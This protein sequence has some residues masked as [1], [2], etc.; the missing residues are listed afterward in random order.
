MFIARRWW[1]RKGLPIIVTGLALGTALVLR[2]TDG[3]VISELYYQVVRPF[4][5]NPQVEDI[6]RNSRI[7]E[8]EIRVTEL[9]QQNQQLKALVGYFEKQHGDVITAPIVGRSADYW[10]QQVTIG[11]G[12]ADGIKEGYAVTGVGGLIGRVTEVTPNTSR[13]LLVSDPNSRV[14]AMVVRSRYMG[15]LQGQGSQT[16]IMRFFDKVPDVKPGDTIATSSVSRLFPGGLPIGK[17]KSVNVTN[18]PAPEAVIEL[19]APLNY[20]EWV[21]VHPFNS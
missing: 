3:A 10:W 8:L 5:V 9:E 2:Y 20:V 15:Y 6:L 12:S 16:A 1:D 19:T 21:V 11:R 17:I 14:G 18:G 13:V 7:E 4:Q